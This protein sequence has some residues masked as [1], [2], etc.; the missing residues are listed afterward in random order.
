MRDELIRLDLITGSLS[1]FCWTLFWIAVGLG[2]LYAAMG[3]VSQG[4]D[5]ILTRGF[6]YSLV[7][8]IAA[9]W[10][11]V[12]IFTKDKARVQAHLERNAP[13]FLTAT[14]EE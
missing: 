11:I 13:P 9:F 14:K 10:R 12:R 6:L 7:A 3:L 1:S 8:I 2:G 5:A 4:A